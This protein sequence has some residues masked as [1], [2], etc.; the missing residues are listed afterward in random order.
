MARHD[1]KV[2]VVTGGASGISRGIV[3]RLVQDGAKVMI[4]DVNAELM[5]HVANE[6]GDSVATHLTDVFDESAVEAL[7]EATVDRFGRLDIAANGALAVSPATRQARLAAAT[8]GG[9]PEFWEQSTAAWHGTVDGILSTVFTCMKYETAQMA[10]QGDGGVVINI[11][12]I[13]ARQPGEG[14]SA[15]AAAK[16]GVEQLVFAAGMELGKHGIRVV[17]IAPGL[18]E[19]P[20]T[21]GG[22]FA[23]PALVA[24]FLRNTP[25]G[26]HGQ[27]ADIGAAASF[28]ASDDASFITAETLTVDG[29]QMTREYPRRSELQLPSS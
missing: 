5:A 12:S 19:T 11:S 21:K 29:G 7:I 22:I 14:G 3:E 17:G 24:S 28:L 27:P 15:Y 10:R 13:N 26:R 9:F 25:I 8:A 20:T 2:A 18:I 23:N 4:A 6:L 16:A 1:G